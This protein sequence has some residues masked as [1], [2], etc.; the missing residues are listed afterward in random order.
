MKKFDQKSTFRLI[1]ILYDH[2]NQGIFNEFS[3]R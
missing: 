3:M 2:K 1:E